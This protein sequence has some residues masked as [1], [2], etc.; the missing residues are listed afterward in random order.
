VI[1]LSR[2]A[3]GQ[4]ADLAKYYGD[5]D[6]PEAVRNL[7]A[8]ITRAADRIETRRGR[9]L[10]APRPYPNLTHP[11]WLWFKEGPYWIAFA[12]APGGDVIQVIFHEVANIPSRI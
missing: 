8:I 10:A 5:Q 2:A 4:I 11:G 1:R 6:R 7:R 3:R 12:S 9:F